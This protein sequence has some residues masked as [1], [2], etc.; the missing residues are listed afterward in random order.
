MGSARLDYMMKVL[1]TSSQLWK[2]QLCNWPVASGMTLRYVV[3]SSEYGVL[4]NISHTGF[5][6]NWLSLT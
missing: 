3:L 1:T 2:P 6:I 4:Q 5:G